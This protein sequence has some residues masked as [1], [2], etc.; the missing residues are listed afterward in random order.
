MPSFSANAEYGRA[1]GFDPAVTNGGSTAAVLHVEATLIDGGVRS[2]SFEAA[3]AKLRQAEAIERQRRA[4]VA[5]EVRSAYF[6]ALAKASERGIQEE[7]AATL[8]EYD[9]WLGRQERQ[10]LAAPGEVERAALARLAAEANA[11]TAASDLVAAEAALVSLT[12]ASVPT[13][14]LAEPAIESSAD[15]SPD[16]VSAAIDAA[17]VAADARA[18]LDAAEREAEAVRSERFGAVKVGADVGALGVQPDT[19]FRRDHGAQFLLQLTV[20]VFDP[21]FSQRLAAAVARGG[22]AR[23]NLEEA[24]RTVALA[25]VRTDAD[26]RRADTDLAAAR[27]AAPLAMRQ[28]ELVRARNAGGGS[29]RLLEVLDALTQ[30]VEARANVSRALFTRRVAVATRAQ[31]LGDATP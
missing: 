5:F 22:V 23:A 12:G 27:K 9:A 3:K 18:A 8:T 24:R 19:T 28:F 4:D 15:L 17:P 1:E 30:S 31:V 6:T 26:L 10:G 25:L 2:A 11:R 7:T 16:A 13:A 29:V 14:G 20:P 21:A